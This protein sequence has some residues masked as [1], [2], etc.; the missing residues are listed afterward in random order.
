[1]E[2][3]VAQLEAIQRD[4]QT[5]RPWFDD[6]FRCL[7]ILQRLTETF[8]ETGSVTAKTIEIRPT[9]VVCSGTATTTRRSSKPSTGC[10]LERCGLPAGR[11]NPRNSPLQ[12]TFNFQWTEGGQP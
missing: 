2:T 4:I 12:F 8:P 7:T 10:A 6:S 11:T 5:Y 1:M 9:S 3:D